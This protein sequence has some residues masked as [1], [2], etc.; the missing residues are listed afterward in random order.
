M[1]NYRSLV[2]VSQRDRQPL[3]PFACS[4]TVV[5][6]QDP[7]ESKS[8]FHWTRLHPT[9]ASMSLAR[10]QL[11]EDLRQSKEKN[12]ST[13]FST[14]NRK[15]SRRQCLLFADGRVKLQR[16]SVQRFDSVD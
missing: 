15:N 9:H 8:K 7:N 11:C 2:Q 4:P 14:C 10:D 16:C 13:P 6:P 3:A 12:A 1:V 5:A